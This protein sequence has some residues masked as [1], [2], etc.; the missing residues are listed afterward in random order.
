MRVV[1]EVIE[2]KGGNE[3]RSEM[4]NSGPFLGI[5]VRAVR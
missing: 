4:T 2:K 5:R 1:L 3:W